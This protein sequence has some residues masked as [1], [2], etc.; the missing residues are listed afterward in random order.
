[1]GSR[2]GEVVAQWVRG[3]MMWKVRMIHS[4]K[5]MSVKIKASI[6]LVRFNLIIIDHLYIFIIELMIITLRSLHYI[7]KL[8]YK[9]LDL[10][11]R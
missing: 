3:Y 1:M 2:W 5:Y 10:E 7:W 8:T 9:W 11:K 6:P 4:R